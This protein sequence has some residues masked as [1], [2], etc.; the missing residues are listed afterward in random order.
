MRRRTL[1]SAV[2][3]ALVLIPGAWAQKISAP[4]DA[5][6]DVDRIF[7]GFHKPDSPGC[8]VGAT[9]GGATVLSAAYGMADLEHNVPI[10][11]QSIFEAGSVS[12][13]FTAG[14]VLLLAQ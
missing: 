2:V 14:A 6:G 10:T 4:P 13:Q 7:A 1:R 5:A 8:A 12:K 9:I 3:F 11:P